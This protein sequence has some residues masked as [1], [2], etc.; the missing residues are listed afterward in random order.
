MTPSEVAFG[1]G[2]VAIGVCVSVALVEISRYRTIIEE[3]CMLVGTLNYASD[4]A[5]SD[6]DLILS[7]KSHLRVISFRLA[8]LDQDTAK[9]LVELILN[10]CTTNAS[11]V[12]LKVRGLDPEDPE[13]VRF[14]KNRDA[15]IKAQ[16][17]R[18]HREHE[19]RWI[20]QLRSCGPDWDGLLL[21]AMRGVGLAPHKTDERVI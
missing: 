16:C 13:L 11:K 2:G 1:I 5:A 17:T 12:T 21:S 20:E 10:E 14:G 18:F 4:R 8:I 15:M 7:Y 3:A 6:L 19:K 9:R